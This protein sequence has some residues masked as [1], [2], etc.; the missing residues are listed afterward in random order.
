MKIDIIMLKENGF[1]LRFGMVKINYYKLDM[2]KKNEE[3]NNGGHD[4]KSLSS[5]CN[6]SMI[7]FLLTTNYN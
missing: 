1:E 3:D 4:L 2:N 7:A 6:Q 5:S